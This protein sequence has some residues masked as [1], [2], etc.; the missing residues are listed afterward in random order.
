MPSFKNPQ[1]PTCFKAYDVR[2]RIGD[3]IDTATVE[4][5]GYAFASIMKPGTVVVGHDCRTTSPTF[6]AAVSKGL[7]RGG[8]DVLD[9]GMAGTEEVY[10]AT[11]HFGAGG[12][13]EI[14]ASH[15]PID[16]NGLKLVGPGSRPLTE[17][18]F[19]EI[20]TLSGADIPSTERPLGAISSVC[21]RDAYSKHLAAM[22]DPN[23][24]APCKIVVNAGSGV[25]GPAFD[26]IFKKLAASGAFIQAVRINHMPDG[27]FPKGI[28]NPLLPENRAETAEMVKQ[29]KADI[30][31]AWDGDFDRCFFFDETGAFVDGEYVVGLLAASFIESEPGATIVHDPRVIWNTQDQVHRRGGKTVFAKTGHAHAKRVM[32]ESGAVYG[33]EI[34]AHHYFR[35]FM[36]CDSGMIPWLK[37]LE[38]MGRTSQPL[39][40]LVRDMQ[41]AFPSSG[42]INFTIADPKASIS[43]VHQHY[44]HIAHDIDWLDGLSMSFDRW[45]L[46]LRMS[47]TEPLVRLNVETKGDKD[48]LRAKTKEVSAFLQGETPAT[49]K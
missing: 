8:A 13:I 47:S 6:A 45:R 46:N 41:S 42:E 15:N 32:R 7:S 49:R 5:I 18:E 40:A 29:S 35:D 39:S 33:G 4:R 23:Q 37:V 28:P 11:A 30:G 44:Q 16:Y 25:A 17:A 10:F 43:R 1:R 26:A 2:G 20:A 38:M 19:D 3:N 24:I 14:T 27:T 36:C 48:L 31:I 9:I 34:S 12:G 22:I 21:A